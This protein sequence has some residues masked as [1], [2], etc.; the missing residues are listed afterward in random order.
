M[1]YNSIFFTITISHFK[2]GPNIWAIIPGI[3]FCF[4]T[5]P[6]LFLVC[7]QVFP[8]VLHVCESGLCCS[9]SAQNAQLETAIQVLPLVSSRA[10]RLDVCCGFT[11]ICTLTFAF[12]FSNRTLSFLGMSLCLSLMFICS[13]YY[14]IIAMGIASCIYK[15][16]EFR[17]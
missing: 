2:C 16:I 4:S 8:H 13:W 15:Y 7:L 10:P 14:A 1:L 12:L 6:C 9:D 17:G 11:R 3:C 5:L